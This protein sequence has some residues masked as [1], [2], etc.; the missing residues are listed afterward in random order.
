MSMLIYALGLCLKEKSHLIKHIYENLY[1][2][3]GPNMFYVYKTIKILFTDNKTYPNRNLI[4]STKG[5]TL[6]GLASLFN[7][8]AYSKQ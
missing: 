5:S 4:I 6:Y 2:I 1:Y 7:I 8:V 3:M